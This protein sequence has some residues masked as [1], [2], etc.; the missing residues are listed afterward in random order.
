[1]S[2]PKVETLPLDDDGDDDGLGCLRGFP[3]GLAITGVVVGAVAVVVW[4][5][6]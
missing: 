2:G 1:M 3:A 6:L 4:V 5:L